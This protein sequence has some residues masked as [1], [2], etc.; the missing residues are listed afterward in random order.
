MKFERPKCT[1]VGFSER[2]PCMKF[3]KP[4]CMA[5]IFSERLLCAQNIIKN[6]NA[7]QLGLD[8]KNILS[9]NI[10]THKTCFPDGN[11]QILNSIYLLNTK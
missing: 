8:L 11:I 2:L 4:K 1:A 7:R 5:V 9:M 3:E 10:V 6:L